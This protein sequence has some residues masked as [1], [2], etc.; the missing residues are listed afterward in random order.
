ML[1]ALLSMGTHCIHTPE[2]RTMGPRSHN[3][4]G[5]ATFDTSNGVPIRNVCCAYQELGKN[6]STLFF[7][8][9]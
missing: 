7:F 5:F 2:V 8:L 4:E 1:A 3:S 9:F 6:A